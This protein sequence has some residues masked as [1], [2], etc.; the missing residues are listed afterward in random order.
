MHEDRQYSIAQALLTDVSWLS[1]SM[2]GAL[3]LALPSM[4]SVHSEARRCKVD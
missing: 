3:A 4:Y 2:T 1:D